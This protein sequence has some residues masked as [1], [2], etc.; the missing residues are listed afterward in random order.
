MQATGSAQTNLSNELAPELRD[1]VI[2]HV[3][4]RF[5]LLQLDVECFCNLRVRG[6][7]T[8]ETE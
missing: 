2:A 1:L 6:G 7:S 8:E 3:E 4:A 5:T